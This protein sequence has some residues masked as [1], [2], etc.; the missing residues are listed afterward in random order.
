MTV[1]APEQL[2]RLIDRYGRWVTQCGTSFSFRCILQPMRYKNKMFLDSQYTKLGVV[3]E[4]CFLYI[5]PANVPIAE[6][7]YPVLYDET[8]QHYVCVKTETVYF[9]NEPLYHWAILRLG[10]YPE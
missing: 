4:S 10:A 3:D 5:G 1:T 8:G 7:V 6:S 9:K 2:R